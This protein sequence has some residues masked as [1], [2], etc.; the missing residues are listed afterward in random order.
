MA[1]V[2]Q[3]SVTAFSDRAIPMRPSPIQKRGLA[4]MAKPTF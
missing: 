3:P 2:S 4:D 1:S